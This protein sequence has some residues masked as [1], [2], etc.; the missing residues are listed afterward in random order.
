MSN[1]HSA[2]ELHASPKISV[3]RFHTCLSFCGFVFLVPDL[4]SLNKFDASNQM[5]GF[6]HSLWV[7]FT[8]LSLHI[9]MQK[10]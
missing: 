9:R 7:N 10:G 1:N 4:F 2:T 5:A 6:H 8:D 3:F